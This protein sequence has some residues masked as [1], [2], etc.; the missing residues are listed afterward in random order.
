VAVGNGESRY[1]V[2]YPPVVLGK[3][4]RLADRATATGRIA[5]YAAALLEM[6]DQLAYRPT[7]WADSV[8]SGDKP[9]VTIHVRYARVLVVEYAVSKTERVVRVRKVSL[10]PGSPLAGPDDT[11][12]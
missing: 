12:A 2:F 11:P 8:W 1:T 6:R 10:P 4:Q 3:I 5:E 7:G 9:G